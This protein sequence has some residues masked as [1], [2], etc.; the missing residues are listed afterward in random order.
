MRNPWTCRR[1]TAALVAAVTASAA[2]AAQAAPGVVD[3]GTLGGDFSDV[4]DMNDLGWIAGR[5][6]DATGIPHAVLW[7][8]GRIM[9][10]D[11]PGAADEPSNALDVNNRGQAE[12]RC[13]RSHERA[14]CRPTRSRSRPRF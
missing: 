8:G 10:I 14:V 3:L 4:G 2:P 9:R 13:G 1:L 12:K 5:A 7:R 6:A 11:I